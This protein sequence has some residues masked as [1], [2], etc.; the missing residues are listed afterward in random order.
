MAESARI[1]DLVLARHGIELARDINFSLADNERVAVV[2]P[3]GCGKSTL[4]SVV[5][6][7]IPPAA[8]KVEL[9][10]NSVGLMDQMP[11]VTQADPV[12]EWIAQ[13]TGVAA[14]AARMERAAEQLAAST[15]PETS[16]EYDVALTEWLSLGGADFEQ[17]MEQILDQLDVG[18]A[19]RQPVGQLSGGQRAKVGLAA[20]ILSRYDILC[21]DEPTNNIDEESLSGLQSFLDARAG[22]LLVVSHDR[23]LLA[24]LSTHVLEF[25][26]ALERVH[27]FAGGYESWRTERERDLQQAQAEFDDYEHE[28]QTLTKQADQAR[29][30]AARGV[31]TVNRKFA[32]GEVDRKLRS[33]M[34][35]GAT[36]GTSKAHTI[37][38]RVERLDPKR[39]PR[40]QWQLRM[41]FPVATANPQILATA[42][43]AV[44]IRGEHRLG[45]ISVSIGRGDRIRVTGSNG[46][47][48]ST[49]V[50]LLTGQLSPSLGSV[51]VPHPELICVLDQDR[52]LPD[53]ANL[54]LAAK[55]L[56]PDAPAD[57]LRAL[58]A[59]FGLGRED[60]D[61]G[62][63]VLSWGER[64]RFALAV[65]T[66]TPSRLLVVDEPTNHLDLMAVE[67]VETA[68]NHYSGA[69]LLVTHDRELQRGLTFTRHWEVD[70]SGAIHELSDV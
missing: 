44:S 25:D 42:V 23:E 22:P 56:L 9:H 61:K 6:G 59:K 35:E 15:D 66:V 57:E 20:T 33:A 16:D 18:A 1:S 12:E 51:S 43:N 8:G 32:T 67:Q 47:G 2:G 46:S 21:L 17:R 26:P 31:S 68:L 70:S 52:E 40:K 58:L 45:P 49:L 5:S 37:Q 60:L 24:A 4:L 30:S 36:S 11:G 38:K 27:L 39:E 69:L 41:D 19:L 28:K 14:A 10:G 34:L 50:R 3:N 29:R 48:K 62:L 13:R 65:M 7:Q 53:V 63:D 55:Q 54:Y 64:T